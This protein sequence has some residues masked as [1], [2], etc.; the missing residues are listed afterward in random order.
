MDKEGGTQKAWTPSKP[1]A[2]FDHMKIGSTVIAPIETGV[3]YV[4]EPIAHAYP[5]ID[6]CSD[7]H[8][9]HKLE[10]ASHILICKVVLTEEG[11]SPSD[12]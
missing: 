2:E 7:G 10:V 3:G 5:S 8:I 6:L 11:A 1:I 9:R 4:M 12:F